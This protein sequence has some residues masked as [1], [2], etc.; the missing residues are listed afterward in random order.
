MANMVTKIDDYGVRKTILIGQESY[1]IALPAI[2][3]GSANAVIKAGEPVTGDIEDR[4]TGFTA[5]TSSPVGIALH[6]VKLDADG[7]GNGTILLAG[8]VD[9]LKLEDSVVTNVN[10]AK[11]NLPKIIFVK[12][13]AI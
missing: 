7:K 10:T 6:E 8:C 12:G 1:Y 3:S 5:S 2:F 11:A 13:S 4:D 9:L